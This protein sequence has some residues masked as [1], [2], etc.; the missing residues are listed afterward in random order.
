MSAQHTRP[1]AISPRELVKQWGGRFSLDLDIRLASGKQGEIF[2]WFLA[3]ILFGAR[4]SEKIA[5][6]T[7]RAFAMARVTTPEAILRTGWDG[8]V[9][10]LDRGGYVRYDYK[11][12]TK[13]LAINRDLM[14]RHGGDLDPLH[15]MAADQEDLAERIRHLGKGI[16]EVTANIFLREMRGVWPKAQPLPS[17]LAV[18]AAKALRFISPRLANR[19][20]I[21][22]RLRDAWQRDGGTA[23]TF[24]DFESA[25]VRVGLEM[26]RK[27][28]R[29]LADVRI[30][31]A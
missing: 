9:A 30:S 17:D 4:I 15:A 1:R 31:A 11:T 22:K 10:I 7:Y 13:L 19:K 18:A 24:P 29:G 5:A 14:E 12:A 6:N 3:S 25:L 2:K 28:A 23:D 8:L 21:L 16:G 27:G 26:R 20:L